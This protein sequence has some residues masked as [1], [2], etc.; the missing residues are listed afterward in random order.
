MRFM[1]APNLT[2][3]PACVFPIA[4]TDDSNLPIAIQCIGRAWE[5]VRILRSYYF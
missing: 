5:E 3:Y 4:Y 2:G 1:H